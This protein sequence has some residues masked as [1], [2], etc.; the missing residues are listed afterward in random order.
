MIHRDIKPSNILINRLGVIKICDFGIS[1]R[2]QNSIALTK[3][4]GCYAYMAVW[5]YLRICWQ[6]LNFVSS[7]SP[8]ELM[9]KWQAT[10]YVRM[11]GVWVWLCTRSLLESIP[12]WKAPP[13][14]FW[15]SPKS[16]KT[17][18]L[19][20][21]VDSSSR[22][23]SV[24]SLKHGELCWVFIVVFAQLFYSSLMKDYKER[25]KYKDLMV[26]LLFSF[27]CFE[28]FLCLLETFVHA[29][30]LSTVSN[31]GRWWMVLPSFW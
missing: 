28:I 31:N 19:H 10:I 23:H 5:V 17:I 20:F 2:L 4:V 1:G 14:S 25:P 22:T 21:P 13:M 6:K 3:Q 26:R 7:T 11:C 9:L 18:H 16:Y 8:N 29:R 15:C 24:I 27:Q 30:Q 12:T